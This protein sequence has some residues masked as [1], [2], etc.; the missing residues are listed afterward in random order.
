MVFFC[1][2][3]AMLL[4]EKI[5]FCWFRW[6]LGLSSLSSSMIL[7]VTHSVPMFFEDSTSSKFLRTS[8]S[9]FCNLRFDS[10]YYL[11]RVL[12][13]FLTW[14][15]VHPLRTFTISLHQFPNSH[16]VFNSKRSSSK[17]KSCLLILGSR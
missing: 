8:P 7:S 17:V 13:Q 15:S 3:R 10:Q 9:S 2:M 1:S 5:P 11:P 12:N 4:S 6:S 16:Y 14:F